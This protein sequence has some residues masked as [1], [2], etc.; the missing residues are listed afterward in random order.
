M[1]DAEAEMVWL[2]LG[3]YLGF[4]L[5]LGLL[6]ILFGMRRL[7]PVEVPGRVRLV[8]LPGMAALWPVILMRLIGLRPKEDRPPEIRT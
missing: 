6:T 8:L 1:S 3:G 5:A 7:T 2:G 4:G